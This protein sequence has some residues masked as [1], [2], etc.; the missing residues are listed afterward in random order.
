MLNLINVPNLWQSRS[1]NCQWGIRLILDFLLHETLRAI[2]V[3][4]SL[5]MSVYW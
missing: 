2:A 4:V 5:R 3:Q 1:W